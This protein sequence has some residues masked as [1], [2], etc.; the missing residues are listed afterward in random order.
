MSDET[1]HTD[2]IDWRAASVECEQ[3][4][5]AALSGIIRFD[6]ADKSKVAGHWAGRIVGAALGRKP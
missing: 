3:I 6:Q 5:H 2:D 4:I 1:I